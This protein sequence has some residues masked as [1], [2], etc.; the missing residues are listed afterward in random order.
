MAKAETSRSNLRVT[1]TQRRNEAALDVRS[2]KNW[3]GVELGVDGSRISGFSQGSTPSPLFLDGGRLLAVH[4]SDRRPAMG[5]PALAWLSHL[6]QP[7][8]RIASEDPPAPSEGTWVV[9]DFRFH[10]GE[11]LPK[12][13]VHYTTLGDPSGEP[14][15]VLHGTTDSG[16]S[17]LSDAFGGEL[18]GPGQPLDARRYYII[19]PD[20]IGHGSSSKPSDGLRA[21]FPEY[22]YTDMVKAQYRLVSEHL[23]V[24]HLRLVTGNSM[25]GMHSWIWAQEHAGYMDAVVPLASLPTA[26]SGR[27]WIT[28]RLI[29]DSI[30]NDPDWNNGNYSKQPTSAQFASV[31][32]GLATNGG[33]QSLQRQAPT[34]EAAD[35]LLDGRMAAPFLADAND[36]LYQWASSGDFDA[37]ADLESITAALLAV[38]SADDERNPPELGI[39]QR[40]I[41]RVPNGS[42]K[43]IP[44]TDQTAGHGTTF[45]AKYWKDDLADLLNAAPYLDRIEAGFAV[46]DADAALEVVDSNR[47]ILANR[48][49]FENA[50]DGSDAQRYQQGSLVALRGDLRDRDADGYADAMRVDA[51]TGYALIATEAG[52]DSSSG[53]QELLRVQ[54]QVDFRKPVNLLRSG[55]WAFN[56]RKLRSV[57]LQVQ[58]TDNA[59]LDPLLEQSSV[60]DLIAAAQL[61]GTDPSFSWSDELASLLKADVFDFQATKVLI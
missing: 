12:L 42:M 43:I 5:E 25:G 26:M 21:D 8:G 17:M 10:T 53:D 38:N 29:T 16:S 41:E 2:D 36:V 55:G 46:V 28:R 47:V 11:V 56:P 49:T 50:S 48:I 15:V 54:F 14:V 34:R 6:V 4:S 51:I 35:A 20:A 58:P 9:K 52:D 22:N 33:D 13:K 1:K 3:M 32:F 31:F 37:S 30:R 45:Q 24:D 57:S 61:T 59:S 19:L 39:L 60:K 7:I 27:N 44:A 18:F 40:E 23:G